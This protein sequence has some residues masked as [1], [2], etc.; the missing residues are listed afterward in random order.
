MKD[1]NKSLD[2]SNNL[3]FLN[4]VIIIKIKVLLPQTYVTFAD[5][6]YSVDALLFS[7]SLRPL[8]YF[9]LFA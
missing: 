7:W 1:F 8:K 9:L 4:H 6:G 2:I 3:Q 5:F